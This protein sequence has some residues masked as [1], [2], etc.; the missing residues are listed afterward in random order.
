MIASFTAFFPGGNDFQL[1][2]ALDNIQFRNVDRATTLPEPTPPEECK[3]VIPNVRHF[4]DK[5]V[6]DHCP[7]GDCPIVVTAR[8]VDYFDI[9]GDQPY[10]A[11][12]P[13]CLSNL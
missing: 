5:F 9:P 12:E 8:G 13:A 6:T 4:K 3:A 1:P 2:V 11:V 10:K 7:T